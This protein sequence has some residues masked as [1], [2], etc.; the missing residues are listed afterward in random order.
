ML[1]LSW[2]TPAFARMIRL[3]MLG[4]RQELDIRLVSSAAE[5]VAWCQHSAAGTAA[6]ERRRLALVIC[7]V[8]CVRETRWIQC[9]KRLEAEGVPVMNP[10]SVLQLTAN[11]LECSMH[12][13]RH[14]IICHPRTWVGSRAAAPA[15]ND[16]AAT[17]TAADEAGNAAGREEKGGSAAGQQTGRKPGVRKR[18]DHQERNEDETVELLSSLLSS[19]DHGQPLIIKPLTSQSQGTHVRK[20]RQD[21]T[22]AEIRRRIRAIPTRTFVIQEYVLATQ[23][24]QTHRPTRRRRLVATA[25]SM[26]CV[27]CTGTFRTRQSIASSS[28]TAK[29]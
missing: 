11:K 19:C 15:A 14:G 18:Q 24:R 27:C 22:K 9:V 5:F 23:R 10:P 6:A 25:L 4:L 1:V 17:A 12:L 13:L 8:A 7:R 21:S 20:L 26:S 3:E 16:L 2:P 28:S 29:H